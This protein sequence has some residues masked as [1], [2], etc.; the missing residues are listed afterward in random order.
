MR[1]VLIEFV[2]CYR[3]YA[4]GFRQFVVALTLGY[5]DMVYRN[6]CHFVAARGD[7]EIVGQWASGPGGAR[8]EPGAI[9]SVCLRLRL[10]SCGLS[11]HLYLQFAALH[12]EMEE[13][14][15]MPCPAVFGLLPACRLP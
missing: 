7:L 5:A 11:P 6:R 1:N 9:P 4:K 13:A 15:V 3:I 10:G 8:P 14:A 12:D 2:A